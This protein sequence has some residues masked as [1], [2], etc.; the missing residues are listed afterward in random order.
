MKT[1]WDNILKQV[2][3]NQLEHFESLSIP[4]SETQLKQ[5]VYRFQKLKSIAISSYTRENL[6]NSAVTTALTLRRF[7]ERVDNPWFSALLTAT[8]RGRGRQYKHQLS[9]ANGAFSHKGRTNGLSFQHILPLNRDDMTTKY[10]PKSRSFFHTPDWFV[11]K[12]NTTLDC[13][14]PNPE[15]L[16]GS[17]RTLDEE[18]NVLLLVDGCDYEYV[19]EIVN[20]RAVTQPAPTLRHY[21]NTK[22]G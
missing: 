6:P 18:N 11:G 5:T 14:C 1:L 16:L 15:E 8:T 12:G 3:D 7:S 10:L 20:K 19:D 17:S 4:M 22:R 9:L 13:D 2:P 21:S